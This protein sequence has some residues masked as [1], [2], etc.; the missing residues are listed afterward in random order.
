MKLNIPPQVLAAVQHVVML[1]VLG[2]LSVSIIPAYDALSNSTASMPVPLQEALNF[3]LPLAYAGF[4]QFKAKIDAELQAEENAKLTAQNA[5]LAK[6]VD[7]QSKEL[8]KASEVSESTLVVSPS[9][10]PQI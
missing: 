9:A 3:I 4:V 5:S 1:A 8:S 2:A 10:F 6:I 7:T